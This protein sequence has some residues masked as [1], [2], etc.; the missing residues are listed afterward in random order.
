[1]PST[2]STAH[3]MMFRRSYPYPKY[4]RQRDRERGRGRERMKFRTGSDKCQKEVQT[5]RTVPTALAGDETS[6]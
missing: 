3:S 4:Q 5:L 2:P 1:M 6:Q